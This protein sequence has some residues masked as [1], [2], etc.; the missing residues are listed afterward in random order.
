L[1]VCGDPEE[2]LDA[3]AWANPRLLLAITV[4]AM[5]NKN[6]KTEL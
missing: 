2:L 1:K 4:P 5:I 3:V 6:V